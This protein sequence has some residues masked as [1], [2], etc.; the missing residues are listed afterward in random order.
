MFSNFKDKPKQVTR[1]TASIL[2]IGQLLNQY[3]LLPACAAEQQAQTVAPENTLF[4]LFVS[5]IAKKGEVL[6]SRDGGD[7]QSFAKQLAILDDAIKSDATSKPFYLCARMDRFHDGSFSSLGDLLPKLVPLSKRRPS[8]NMEFRTIKKLDVSQAMQL[9]L[10][11]NLPIAISNQSLNVSKWNYAGALGGFAPTATLDLQTNGARRYTATLPRLPVN[12]DTTQ[13]SARVDYGLFQGGKVLFS[14]INT[15]ELF[16][17]QKGSFAATRND[18]LNQAVINYYNLLASQAI[19]NV[20]MDSALFCV[21]QLKEFKALYKIQAAL[22]A[23]TLNNAAAQATDFTEATGFVWSDTNAISDTLR[24]LR[25]LLSQT[26]LKGANNAVLYKL[27]ET[28]NQLLST[29]ARKKASSFTSKYAE[30]TLKLLKANEEYKSA[31]VNEA[32]LDIGLPESTTGANDLATPDAVRSAQTRYGL[33]LTLCNDWLRDFEAIR[34]DFTVKPADQPARGSDSEK[35]ARLAKDPKLSI[36]T[37][38]LLE[39]AEELLSLDEQTTQQA[40]YSEVSSLTSDIKSLLNILRQPTSDEIRKQFKQS[41]KLLTSSRWKASTENAQK[42]SNLYGS[43][44]I[45]M[46]RAAQAKDISASQRL[47]IITLLDYLTSKASAFQ[48]L[49]DNLESI[50]EVN[51]AQIQKSKDV[52][53]FLSNLDV[54][55][56]QLRSNIDLS[57]VTDTALANQI[58]VLC[59]EIESSAK[60]SSPSIA[61]NIRLLISRLKENSRALRSQSQVS[62]VVLSQASVNL[63]KALQIETTEAGYAYQVDQWNTQ[64]ANDIQDILSQYLTLRTSSIQLATLLNLDQRTCLLSSEDTLACKARDLSYLGFVELV[65]QTLNNRPELFTSDEL[66]R[67][68]LANVAVAASALMPTVSVFGQI[69]SSGTSNRFDTIH[70]VRSKSFGLQAT[71][72]FTNLLLPSMANVAAQGANAIQAYL[73]FRDQLNQVMKEIHNSYISVQTA[74]LRVATAIQK[75]QKAT[76]QIDEANTPEERMKASA[77]NLDLITA[78]RD[79]N[80][81]MVDAANQMAAYNTAQAQLLRDSGQ[82]YPISNFL[83]P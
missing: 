19:L 18:N 27:D 38:Q 35:I 82:I 81:A 67:A 43:V 52:V 53:S 12:A 63:R 57:A 61:S 8:P 26:N 80:T 31:L 2:V 69:N 20:R 15:H 17:A 40:V 30:L 83:L 59:N 34:S 3:A 9:T 50:A 36:Q 28:N 33:L 55:L 73:K 39:G 48:Q 32:D 56:S 74:K 5:K 79:R 54:Q 47:K 6:E 76:K 72:R 44:T 60:N 66:R 1:I 70:L 75:A 46:A 64:L 23:Q 14:A 4:K 11:Q 42:L 78:L 77:S 13:L 65:R 49:A 45:I 68:A 71:Y 7:P 21:R 10:N 37:K 41:L 29:R 22:A 16:L 25:S 24:T 51:S 62:K 58:D